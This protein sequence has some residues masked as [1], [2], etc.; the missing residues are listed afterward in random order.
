MR[1]GVS[2]PELRSL[3]ERLSQL[4]AGEVRVSHATVEERE[5]SDEDYVLVVLR[6]VPPTGES[7]PLDDFYELRKA[8]R[9][10][11]TAALE[12]REV[13]LSYTSDEIQGGNGTEVE[14]DGPGTKP[15]AEGD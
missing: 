6:L 7:W 9:E 13:Q 8:A 3:E 1:M 2:G 4:A 11:A 15:S 5:D 10:L 12:G 14:S